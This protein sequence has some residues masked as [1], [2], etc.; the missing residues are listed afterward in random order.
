MKNGQLEF[1]GETKQRENGKWYAE[2]ILK[3]TGH[4]ARV[5][6]GEDVDTETEAER[7]TVESIELAVLE[8][9][10]PNSPVMRTWNGNVIGEA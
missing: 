6:M 7:Q 3:Q 1:E 9:G 5:F 10:E 4:E 2:I 8:H